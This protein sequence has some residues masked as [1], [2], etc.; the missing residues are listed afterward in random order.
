MSSV[1][2]FKLMICLKH[3]C[4]LAQCCAWIHLLFFIHHLASKVNHRHETEELN[5]RVSDMLVEGLAKLRHVSG[6]A[7]RKELEH[8]RWYIG[9][10]MHSQSRETRQNVHVAY[11]KWELLQEHIFVQYSWLKD[12][13]DAP[14]TLEVT[15]DRQYRER[16]LI[17]ICDE[18]FEC[19]KVIEGIRVHAMNMSK[20]M[21][22]DQKAEFADD[23]VKT[24][25]D[26][27]VAATWK[28]AFRDV[29]DTKE[30]STDA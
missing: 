7:I 4:H 10:N 3:I 14:G 18:A 23:A 12:N 21:S 30:V 8:C 2:S 27:T 26:A 16:G 1:P 13:T 15:E 5:F 19:F 11:A 25:N 17:H 24:I 9:Q 20:M 29:E 28:P 22:S 6:W